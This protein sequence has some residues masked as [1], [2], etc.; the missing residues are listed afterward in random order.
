MH[1]RKWRDSSAFL[2]LEVYEKVFDFL[3]PMNRSDQPVHKLRHPLIFY[4]HTAVLHE[5]ACMRG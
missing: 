5:Q 4:A 2:H 1:L 3:N